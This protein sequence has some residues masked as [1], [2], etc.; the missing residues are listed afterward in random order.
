MI[1]FQP[2]V[3]MT[4]TPDTDSNAEIGIPKYIVLNIKIPFETTSTYVLMVLSP[5]NGDN[6][7]FQ[8]CAVVLV[9]AGKNLPCI[10]MYRTAVYSSRTAAD[11][12]ADTAVLDLG[13]VSNVPIEASSVAADSIKVGI[14]ITP[15]VYATGPNYDLA[16]SLTYA[17]ARVDQVAHT[18]TMSGT[19]SPPVRL[20]SILY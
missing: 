15:L 14:T 10:Q 9:S 7:V 20:N 19:S 16:V 6:P 2:S 4:L 11:E 18:F 13:G 12:Y 1:T 3:L 17:G 5:L 8:I